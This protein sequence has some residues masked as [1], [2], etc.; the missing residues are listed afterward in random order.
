MFLVLFAH[1][2]FIVVVCSYNWTRA[3]LNI[4]FFRASMDSQH[5]T[6]ST[7][8]ADWPR[9]DCQLQPQPLLPVAGTTA[10]VPVDTVPLSPKREIPQYRT[11]F[12]PFVLRPDNK[13]F[14]EDGSTR[15][16][17]STMLKVGLQSFLFVFKIKHSCLVIC[18]LFIDFV[19]HAGPSW[20]EF[21][22]KL[23]CN[24]VEACC[25]L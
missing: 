5:G 8:L 15:D 19:L 13:I 9:S 22:C 12:K 2:V 24:V 1:P 4:M 20:R 3:W 25:R 14:V 16:S 6:S 21:R 17:S 10:V 11:K 23:L 7:K 18:C